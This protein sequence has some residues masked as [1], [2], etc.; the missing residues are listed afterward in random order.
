MVESREY[1]AAVDRSSCILLCRFTGRKT[2][3]KFRGKTD[4]STKP[5]D[6]NA[7]VPVEKE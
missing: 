3:L 1:I 5:S 6:F 4:K 7:D 2:K